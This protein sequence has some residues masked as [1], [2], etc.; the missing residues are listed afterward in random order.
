MSSLI[1]AMWSGMRRRCSRTRFACSSFISEYRP[2]MTKWRCVGSG[3][4]QRLRTR[5]DLDQL[6]RDHGL[7]R[8]VVAHREPVDHIARVAGRAVHRAHARALLGGGILEQ[9]PKHLCRG[10]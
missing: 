2:R 6:L 10:V 3:P 9:P 5:D 7:A 1:T 4:L 8:A